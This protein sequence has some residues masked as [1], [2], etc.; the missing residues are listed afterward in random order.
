MRP[1]SR[2]AVTNSDAPNAQLRVR[3]AQLGAD[4]RGAFMAWLRQHGYYP[5]QAAEAGEDGTAVVRFTVDRQGRVSGLQLIGRS[6]SIWLDAGAQAM[7]RGRTVP[8]FPPGTRDD[9]AEIDLTINYIL[10]RR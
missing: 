6:G 5:Q 10:R 8:P 9:T 7:L 4:W 2:S 3:G 1:E